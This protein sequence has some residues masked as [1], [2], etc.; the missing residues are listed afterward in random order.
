MRADCQ[1]RRHLDPSPVV[2]IGRT[3]VGIAARSTGGEHL[4]HT[5]STLSDEEQRV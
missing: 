3:I 1:Y 2:R 4:A 5:D